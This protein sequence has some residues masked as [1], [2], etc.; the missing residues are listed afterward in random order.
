V[1][2]GPACRSL[3]WSRKLATPPP[4]VAALDT[5]KGGLRTTQSPFELSEWLVSSAPAPARVVSG[6]ASR[7]SGGTLLAARV[8]FKSISDQGF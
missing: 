8:P 2:R 5:E 3:T 7:C 4:L 1:D 6:R